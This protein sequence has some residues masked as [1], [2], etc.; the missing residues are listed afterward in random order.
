MSLELELVALRDTVTTLNKTFLELIKQLERGIPTERIE[1]PAPKRRK[2]DAEVAAEPPAE[3]PGQQKVFPPEA[4]TPGPAPAAET[5]PAPASEDA[6]KDA[7][8]AFVQKHSPSMGQDGA[9][10]KARE[11]LG[12]VGATKV[13]DTPADK[14]A[15]VVRLLG[16]V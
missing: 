14:R 12:T 2:K 3:I 1:A 8:I 4:P 9:K 5:A 13:S 6:L 7:L 15:E 16:E 10:A 11:I